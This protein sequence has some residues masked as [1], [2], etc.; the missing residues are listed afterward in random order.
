MTRVEQQPVGSSTA[1]ITVVVAD[2]DSL[3]RA[4]IVLILQAQPDIVVVGEASDGCRAVELA[5]DLQPDVVLMDVRMPAMNGIEA[6]EAI[7]AASRPDPL[8]RVLVLTTFHTDEAVYGAIR[9]GASGFVL[10][11]AA[12]D[13]LGL[14]VRAVA[15][16][17][18]WLDPAV[19]RG[20][21][22]EL[23][24]RPTATS[25]HP[26]SL[27]ELTPREAEVLVEVAHGFS[28]TEI[29]RRLVVGEA[30]VKTHV[31]RILMKLGVKDR[32]PG[33]RR[34]LSHRP[35]RAAG[36]AAA[37]CRARLRVHRWTY[38]ED[39]SVG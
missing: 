19:A 22:D 6:T 33:R 24:A 36:P 34:G 29:A 10:K 14:A 3:V 27:A 13:E 23:A 25:T 32:G 28:N 4:G 38:G 21:L 17:E 20:L 39:H 37:T 35:G 8:V 26:G 31:S 30:T 9:A 12:P 16:G 2:D 18:A 5:R 1:T 15:A 7:V 11:A